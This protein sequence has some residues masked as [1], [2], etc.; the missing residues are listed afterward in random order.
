MISLNS[1]PPAGSLTGR[2]LVISHSGNVAELTE[3]SG[4]L[5]V[6][7]PDVYQVVGPLLC[8]NFKRFLRGEEK[9]RLK[10]PVDIIP[11]FMGRYDAAGCLAFGVGF[12]PRI[13]QVLQAAGA[14]VD[15]IDL[16][17]PHHRPNR[18]QEN[19]DLVARNISFRPLQS[20]ALVMMSACQRGLIDWP[21]AA[22][23][24]VLIRAIPLLYPNAVVHVVVEGRDLVNKTVDMLHRSVPTVGVVMGSKRRPERVTV[25]S[26]DSLHL[27]DGDAD[28]LLYDEVHQAAAPSYAQGLAVYTRSRNFGFSASLYVRPDGADFELEAI[29]GRVINRLTYQECVAA[30]LVNQIYVNWTPVYMSDN[31]AE[32]ISNETVRKRHGIWRNEVRNRVVASRALSYAPDEQTLVLVET[33]EHLMFLRKHLPGFE[34]VYVGDNMGDRDPAFYRKHGMMGE[35]EEPV[36][37]ER[38]EQLRKGFESGEIKKVIANSVWDTGVDFVNLAVEIRADALNS[39][40][41]D[42]QAP[43]RTARISSGK[44]RSVIEDFIDLWDRKMEDRARQVRNSY[45]SRGWEDNWDDVMGRKL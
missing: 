42:I 14:V 15:T 28:F 1:Q 19:W 37:P 6:A 41:K 36:S 4:S 7:C 8:Y 12:A 31:P 35:N 29:F 38:R 10:K 23:K 22:G 40:T 11:R 44:S 25:Y 2:H 17:P 26:A 9:K 5:L 39:R 33:V 21:T 18:Y 32:G 13:T 27:S 20:E 24:G 34:A 30:G 3:R 16:D 43:G 45:R